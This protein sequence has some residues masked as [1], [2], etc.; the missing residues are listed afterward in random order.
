MDIRTNL[1]KL[2]PAL[3]ALL[4]PATALAQGLGTVP[5]PGGTLGGNDLVGA[6]ILILNGL[7]VLAGVVAL[8]YLIM[9]GVRYITSGGDDDAIGTAKNTILY[10]IIGL[11]VIGVAAV[12]V[13]FIIASVLPGGG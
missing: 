2:V 9:G 12:A 13:N 4:F 1:K 5:A 6:I 3:P 7:L 8:V 11:I 10:A